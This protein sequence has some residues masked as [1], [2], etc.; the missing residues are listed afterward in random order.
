MSKS[1]IK[2][3]ASNGAFPHLQMITEKSI[4]ISKEIELLKERKKLGTSKLALFNQEQQFEKTELEILLL[5]TER[6]LSALFKKKN[7]TDTYVANYLTTLE[8]LSNEY[9]IEWDD[10]QLKA[11]QLKGSKQEKINRVHETF[12]EFDLNT[13]HEAKLL[14]FAELKKILNKKTKE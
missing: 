10:I 3:N 7:D 9:E 6:E 4:S 12:A 2:I 1:K 5:R 14:Y 8:K 11:S 13:N